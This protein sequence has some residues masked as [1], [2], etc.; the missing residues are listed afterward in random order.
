MENERREKD[1]KNNHLLLHKIKQYDLLA[2]CGL[3]SNYFIG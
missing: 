3:L 1:R 2:A